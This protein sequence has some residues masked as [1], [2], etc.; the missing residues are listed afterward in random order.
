MDFEKRLQKAI[1]RGQRRN[2]AIRRE[3]RSKAIS[4]EEL[5]SLHGQY[6]LQLSEQIEHCIQRLPNYFPGFQYETI[7]GERG[8][9]G[10]CSRDDIR[11]HSGGKRTKD[12]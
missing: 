10:A 6:R 8:W 9:G 1:Q 3:V 2:E 4:E 11:M 5:K 12:Y 7:F